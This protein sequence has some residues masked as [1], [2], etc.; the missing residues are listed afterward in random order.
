MLR[1]TLL[2]TVCRA[3]FIDI[4]LCIVLKFQNELENSYTGK[5]EIIY[6][7]RWLGWVNWCWT[8]GVRWMFLTYAALWASSR[9][10]PPAYTLDAK[11]QNLRGTDH[12][13]TYTLPFKIKFSG[14]K[15]WFRCMH[16]FLCFLLTNLILILDYCFVALLSLIN[17]Y[18]EHVNQFKIV[19]AYLCFCTVCP[20]PTFSIFCIS[21]IL[22]ADPKHYHLRGCWQVCYTLMLL[23]HNLRVTEWNSSLLCNTLVNVPHT[24][25]HTQGVEH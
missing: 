3:C 11:P 9:L 13:L 4:H 20:G 8:L 12:I 21:I 23:L 5:T 6:L 2:S 10:W 15:S 1:I 14:A 7:H 16:V 17:L 19:L 25:T 22:K 18:A 24:D